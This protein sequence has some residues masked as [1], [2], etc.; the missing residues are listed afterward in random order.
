MQEIVFASDNEIISRIC[1]G[2]APE[3]LGVIIAQLMVSVSWLSPH[4]QHS[5]NIGAH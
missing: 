1:V 4:L 5:P 2:R 3:S